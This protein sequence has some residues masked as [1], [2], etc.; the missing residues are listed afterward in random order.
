[1]SPGLFRLAIGQPSQWQ[2]N[3]KAAV[4]YL[5]LTESG[6]SQNGI[7]L[8]PLNLYLCYQQGVG[9]GTALLMAVQ[10]GTAST[11]PATPNELAQLTGQRK[12]LAQ[13]KASTGHGLTVQDF[14]D[15]FSAKF[16]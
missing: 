8:T 16:E 6:M 11:T 12:L 5:E 9:G 2:Q 10:D 15:Y 13:L 7:E 4:K 3:V 14:Y 1:M